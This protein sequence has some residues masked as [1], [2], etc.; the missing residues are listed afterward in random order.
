MCP[1]NAHPL[2]QDPRSSTVTLEHSECICWAVSKMCTPCPIGEEKLLTWS[3]LAP[4]SPGLPLT[5]WGG[6][7]DNTGCLTVICLSSVFLSVCLSSVSR[8]SVCL[9]FLCQSV[10]RLSVCLSVCLS[11]YRLSVSCLSVVLTV[12][13]LFP[14]LPCKQTWCCVELLF[15]RTI[16][17]VSKIHWIEVLWLYVSYILM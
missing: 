4:C 12:A 8:L 1:E 15:Y 6:H 16:D 7:E 2:S 10:C 14:A 17:Y 13:P 11:V 9:S 3:P 5:P